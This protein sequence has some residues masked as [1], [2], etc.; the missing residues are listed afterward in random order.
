MIEFMLN[1]FVHMGIILVLAIATLATAV[2][3]AYKPGERKLGILRP[4]SAATLFSILSALCAGISATLVH[5]LS[6]AD[7]AVGLEITRSLMPGLAEAMVPGIVGFTILAL[8]WLLAAVGL[9]R[10]M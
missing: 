2:S 9:R 1:G 3:F 4:M 8:S 10:Q 7:K 6:P 5:A